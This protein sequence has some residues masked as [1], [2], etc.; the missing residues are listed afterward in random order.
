MSCEVPDF[1]T[2]QVT[3]LS[4]RL[5]SKIDASMINYSC[6]LFLSLDYQFQVLILASFRLFKTFFQGLLYP[7]KSSGFA[8]YVLSEKEIQKL[9][10]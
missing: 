10:L 3:L 6:Y 8:Q 2:R 1:V 9:F 7:E 5:E 4:L